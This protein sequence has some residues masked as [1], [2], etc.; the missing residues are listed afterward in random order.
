M[1]AFS[2]WNSKGKGRKRWSKSAWP[3]RASTYQQ[4]DAIFVVTKQRPQ[5]KWKVFLNSVDDR[6]KSELSVRTLAADLKKRNPN[7]RNFHF[8]RLSV[9]FWTAFIVKLN[10]SWN[11][12]EIN[13]IGRELWP[14]I[15]ALRTDAIQFHCAHTMQLTCLLDSSEKWQVRN[16]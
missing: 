1:I 7:I 16:S 3:S 14:R 5:R 15:D 8:L 2:F 12:R 13:R 9:S 4:M 11:T 10:H 6:W